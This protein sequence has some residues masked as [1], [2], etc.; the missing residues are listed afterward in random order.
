MSDIP[1]DR[2]GE[3]S[4]SN[5]NFD[6]VRIAEPFPLV[7]QPNFPAVIG[8]SNAPTSSGP[9]INYPIAVSLGGT[10]FGSYVIGDILYADSV[11]SLAKLGIGAQG[12]VLTVDAGLPVWAAPS[13]MGFIGGSGTANKIPKFATGSTLTDSVMTES[14]SKIGFNATNPFYLVDIDGE[15]RLRSAN[16]L[17][18]GGT[19]GVGDTALFQE[20]AGRLRLSGQ[21]LV[22]NSTGPSPDPYSTDVVLS[23]SRTGVGESAYMSILAENWAGIEF[24]QHSA[25]V[26]GYPDFRG[27]LRYDLTG[28]ELYVDIGGTNIVAVTGNGMD[29]SGHITGLTFGRV[30]IEEIVAS[31]FALRVRN[32][33]ATGFGGEFLTT[34]NTLDALRVSDDNSNPIHRFFG[35]GNANFS[36]GGGTAS[37]GGSVTVFG[38]VTGTWDGAIISTLKGGT[39]LNSY[40]TGD[41]IYASAANTLSKLAVGTDGHI[42]TLAAGVPSW[43]AAPGGGVGGSGTAGKIS[44]FTAAT[45]LADS[46]LSESGTTITSNGSVL[47]APVSLVG[48]Q[49]SRS[50]ILQ[51]YSSGTPVDWTIKS[52][53]SSL[54]IGIQKLSIQDYAGVTRLLMDSNG[55]TTVGGSLEISGVTNAALT[56]R[57]ASATNFGT[58]DFYTTT[59]RHYYISHFDDN[60]LR[61]TGTTTPGF[62]FVLNSS[63]NIGLGTAS[64][65]ASMV[66][67]ISFKSGTAPTGNVADCFQFYSADIVAGNAA[68][69]FRTEN[70]DIIKLFKSAVYTP[71][72]VSADRAFDANATTLD[73]VADALGTLIADLQATGLIG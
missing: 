37:F 38:T 67:G 5:I 2:T 63:G 3:P 44:K 25:G 57:K 8:G 49:D 56:F 45:T 16:K 32:L 71:T 28:Q 27:A 53:S 69:H 64:Y 55:K 34:D 24:Y 51:A 70:G 40:T 65:G 54:S 46:L 19:T 15:A 42:L 21:L 11:S 22:T 31:D 4:S 62:D 1:F 52:D 72:N 43:A 39:G 9:S 12:F 17:W 29:V 66:G 50:L 13:G 60:T 59:V 41:I 36:I 7:N 26:P 10:G 18:F 58:M 20:I 68:P 35:N 30:L 48:Y 73:E 47:L 6:N 14:S 33:D 61:I 23:I